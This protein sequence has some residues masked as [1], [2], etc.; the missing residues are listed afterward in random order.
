L[1]VIVRAA[2]GVFDSER[3]IE[4]DVDVVPRPHVDVPDTFDTGGVSVWVVRTGNNATL[5]VKRSAAAWTMSQQV[6]LNGRWDHKL[7]TFNERRKH[8]TALITII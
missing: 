2:G 3:L 6:G 8:L 4:G 5:S 1:D 7:L